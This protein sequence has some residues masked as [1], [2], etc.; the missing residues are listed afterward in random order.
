MTLSFVQVS[1]SLGH[2]YKLHGYVE[3]DHKEHLLDE[4]DEDLEKEG[5]LAHFSPYLM[6]VESQSSRNDEVSNHSH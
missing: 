1:F 5:T 2:D 6:C 3:L 4:A